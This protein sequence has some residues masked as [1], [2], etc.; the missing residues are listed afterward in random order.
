MK[1]IGGYKV[2]PA[3]NLF[4]LM[5]VYAFAN[6]CSSIDNYGLIHPII[7]KDGVLIDGRL[8]LMAAIKLNTKYKEENNSRRIIIP[9]VELSDDIENVTDYIF[10]ININRS[11]LTP[12]QANDIY[13]GYLPVIAKERK[14]TK[15]NPV[16]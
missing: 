11:H 1:T 9:T 6:L 8:R 16:K 3:L 12:D 7:L 14:R 13:K 10:N 5:E 15:T 2:H 4:P